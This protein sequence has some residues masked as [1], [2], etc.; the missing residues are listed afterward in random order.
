MSGQTRNVIVIG[1]GIAGMTIAKE[2]VKQGLSVTILEAASRLGGKAG[3]DQN[4][5]RNGDWEDHGY[6][7]F[8]GWYLNTRLLLEEVGAAKNLIDVDRT[9]FLLKPPE[10]ATGNAPANKRNLITFYQFSGI[11]AL[12][13]NYLS[14]TKLLS[15]I[16]ALLAI[17]AA[18]D[19]LSERWSRR[20][21]LDRVSANGFLQGRSYVTE[22]VAQLQQ[23]TV[24]QA[25]SIP[26]YEVSAMTIKLVIDYWVRNPKPFYSFL[27]DSLQ[28]TFIRPFE[29]YILNL[30][31]R[32]G[33][34]ITI[35]TNW[36]VKRIVGGKSGVTGIE[37]EGGGMREVG[38]AD[39]VVLAT[40]LEVT[41]L[42]VGADIYEAESGVTAV[43][44][45]EYRPV[46]GDLRHLETAPMAALTLYFKKKIPGIPK[47]HVNLYGSLLKTSFIDISQHWS[48]LH[49]QGGTVLDVIASDFVALQDL[50]H[51]NM[52]ELIIKD[53]LDYLQLGQSDVQDHSLHDNVHKPLFLNTVGCW[54][55][56][57]R[58]RTMIQNLYIAGDYCQTVADLTTME[59]AI[60]SGIR[61]AS[62]LLQDLEHPTESAIEWSILTASD[63]LK[64]LERPTNIKLLPLEYMSR[65]QI[66]LW[67]IPLWP[68]A[69][70]HFLFRLGC[71]LVVAPLKAMKILGS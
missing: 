65:M 67:K 56:R 69:Y 25:S 35:L 45:N 11:L 37:R 14:M 16:D 17:F 15:K 21:F 18:I 29:S 8:P 6:H 44:D 19:L 13:K 71:K 63:L 3:S 55:H 60:E 46:L 2:V 66:W 33:A 12:V 58:S 1:G 32:N 42:I 5:N 9:H 34:K 62:K 50:P 36:T 28:E 43:R 47:E 64:D 23:Q 20:E 39:R 57:P 30:A 41:R 38:A 26:S 40:P 54:D 27:N 31:E 68:I 22:K 24:L 51:D 10:N 7:V 70:G 4:Q 52:A 53:V 59:S 49:N 48:S 61:T